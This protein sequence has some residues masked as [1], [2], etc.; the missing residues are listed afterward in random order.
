MHQLSD[1]V[2][3]LAGGLNTALTPRFKKMLL[4]LED[5]WLADLEQ[6]YVKIYAEKQDGRNVQGIHRHRQAPE[7]MGCAPCKY[8]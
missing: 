4:E 5:G 3:Q 6:R 1:G 2:A 7:R 8:S